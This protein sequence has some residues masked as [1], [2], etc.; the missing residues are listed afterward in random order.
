VPFD[1][2]CLASSIATLPSWLIHSLYS[3][4][5]D[6]CSDPR[7]IELTRDLVSFLNYSN[8]EHELNEAVRTVRMWNE[9]ARKTYSNFTNNANTAERS[10]STTLWD[11][12]REHSIQPKALVTFCYLLVASPATSQGLSL[13]AA[14]AYLSLLEYSFLTR[15]AS[16]TI[17]H[18]L[19]MRSCQTLLRAFARVEHG[20]IE[21]H[22][23]ARKAR[24]KKHGK[25]KAGE[26][27]FGDDMDETDASESL[28]PHTWM[29]SCSELCVAFAVDYL[30]Q[31]ERLYT[32]PSA[33]I[34]PLFALG[35]HPDLLA[36]LIETMLDLARIEV[37]FSPGARRTAE[38]VSRSHSTVAETA[39]AIVLSF[40]HPAHGGLSATLQLLLKSALSQV[41]FSAGLGHATSGAPV[42]PSVAGNT[43]GLKAIMER[44]SNFV[45]EIWNKAG[46]N[47]PHVPVSAAAVAGG[48]PAAPRCNPAIVL[49]SAGSFL[50]HVLLRSCVSS[51][52]SASSRSALSNLYSH[53]L[54]LFPSVRV[55]QAE[56]LSKMARNSRVNIR[57]FAVEIAEGVLTSGEWPWSCVTDAQ[58]GS[59]ARQLLVLILR[60][61][62][63]ASP[64]VR[65]KALGALTKVLEFSGAAGNEE[66]RI[67]LQRIM[68]SSLGT[69]APAGN[70]GGNLDFTAAAGLQRT[71][72]EGASPAGGPANNNNNT[73]GT[74]PAMSRSKSAFTHTPLSSLRMRGAAAGGSAAPD[75]NVSLTLD[76]SC[77]PSGGA[78][79]LHPLLAGVRDILTVLYRRSRDEKAVVRKAAI[80]ALEALLL[81]AAPA[82]NQ[83][84]EDEQD[85]EESNESRDRNLNSSTAAAAQS[86][87]AALTAADLQ[88]FY[89][90]CSDAN[91]SIRK[92]SILSLSSLLRRFVF[93]SSPTPSAPACEILSIARSN[94]QR[95][96]LG[97]VLP[98]VKDAEKSIEDAALQL[99]EEFLV[100]PLVQT[101]RN[102]QKENKKAIAAGKKA[103][104]KD[105]ESADPAHTQ[106]EEPVWS[107][108]SMLCADG[109]MSH[110]FQLAFSALLRADVQPSSGNTKR[111]DWTAAE[112]AKLVGKE[113]LEAMRP[114]ESNNT[115]SNESIEPTRPLENDAD[116]TND[117]LAF[118]PTAVASP[119]QSSIDPSR[120]RVLWTLMDSLCSACSSSP[121]CSS[122]LFSTVL[123]VW[124]AVTTPEDA[125][126][127]CVSEETLTRAIGCFV[128]LADASATGKSSAVKPEDAAQAAGYIVD[129]L[130]SCIA[131][132]GKNAVKVK[133]PEN[134]EKKDVTTSTLLSPQV[135]KKK[136]A[137][138][139]SLCA[140]LA[141]SAGNG[142]GMPPW[143]STLLAACEKA[144]A[145]FLKA[146]SQVALQA[147]PK[148]KKKDA[149]KNT[150]QQQQPK[151]KI[152]NESGL[153]STLFLTGEIL[154]QHVCFVAK[155]NSS[156]AATITPTMLRLLHTF[157]APVL[158]F[159]A[160]GEKNKSIATTTKGDVGKK[161]EPQEKNGAAMDTDQNDNN[162]SDQLNISAI[163]VSELDLTQTQSAS[164]DVSFEL[165]ASQTTTTA[166][167]P[168]GEPEVIPDASAPFGALVLSPAVRGHAFLA[169]GKACLRHEQLAKRSIQLFIQEL[170]RTS[171][172][173]SASASASASPLVQNNILLILMD[174]CR[175]YTS[176]VDPYLGTMSSLLSPLR[177]PPLL[178]KHAVMVLDLLVR[179]DYLKVKSNVHSE[180]G[181]GAASGAASSASGS[182]SLF[183]RFLRG[184]VDSDPATRSL[185]E[186][187]VR[188]MLVSSPVSGGT[189]GKIGA[190]SSGAGAGVNSGSTRIHMHFIELIFFLNNCTAHP[191]YN[192]FNA[193]SSSKTATSSSKS[194]SRD[195]EFALPGPIGSEEAARRF[196]IYKFCLSPEFLSDEQKFFLMDRLVAD[197]LNRVVE[198][199]FSVKRA[200]W[201]D[202]LSPERIRDVVQDT[203]L[204]LASEQMQL[205][206]AAAAGSGAKKD[207][208]AV[209]ALELQAELAE[210]ALAG[211]GGDSALGLPTGGSSRA[212]AAALATA[213]AQSIAKRK[214]LLKLL[215]KNTMETIWPVLFELKQI[216]YKASSLSSSSSTQELAPKNL[217]GP[218]VS[219]LSNYLLHYFSAL[220]SQ[221]RIENEEY[222]FSSNRLWEKEIKFDLRRWKQGL[223]AGHNGLQSADDSEATEE[224][225]QTQ[226][227]WSTLH[228]TPPK[229]KATTRFFSSSSGNALGFTPLLPSSA[230]NTSSPMAIRR[231]RSQPVPVSSPVE[232]VLRPEINLRNVAQFSPVPKLPQF[233]SPAVPQR[234]GSNVA[235]EG[236][237][238]L[239]FS[240]LS[241]LRVAT[242]LMTATTSTPAPARSLSAVALGTPLASSLTPAPLRTV[243]L[244]TPSSS[245]P[246]AAARSLSSAA[247]AVLG[248]PMFVSPTLRRTASMGN[249]AMK[250]PSFTPR[251]ARITNA[252]PK[253]ANR[254]QQGTK[255][256][257]THHVEE[258]EEE[259]DDDQD[260]SAQHTSA[261][262]AEVLSD[263][264]TDSGGDDG[265]DAAGATS[266]NQ[267]ANIVV[268]PNL[269][270][271]KSKAAKDKVW[272]V[273]LGT[274][275]E[276]EEEKQHG[277]EA[278]ASKKRR[279]NER[280]EPEQEAEQPAPQK[281][282]TNKPRKAAGLR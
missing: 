261:A 94:L 80:Q 11:V 137:L 196:R 184:L 116:M 243:S 262:V 23:T 91:L 250:P 187:S 198:D 183:Y 206:S 223:G 181:G 81:G 92:Q 207:G 231:T 61:C 62:S 72:S 8:G 101:M 170:E 43:N 270:A 52:S 195:G 247:A 78:A 211:S 5:L 201:M 58:E 88:I 253:S 42:A 121:V 174:L 90:G 155:S 273:R 258:G 267:E 35:R 248:T 114:P 85:K 191:L 27:P 244:G 203:L 157:I 68:R 279:K 47:A 108:L 37:L 21:N 197:V 160:Q 177:S 1:T 135:L 18:E 95:I 200:E 159:A 229:P 12:L 96:W 165:E 149:Q 162:A 118:P 102:K 144:L 84:Q 32:A 274:T 188:N 186:A 239:K 236:N 238:P 24:E 264:D 128:A 74:T 235:Q 180:A 226:S 153:C 232:R 82:E 124:N 98:M 7:C 164:N 59:F 14:A 152:L 64:S 269:D 104:K 221:Y 154:L 70:E 140:L 208:D 106:Q 218:S 185:V 281:Q 87:L 109:E 56:F 33:Q 282:V 28:N 249:S 77:F 167:E 29:E 127:I 242:P 255:R 268:V 277:E 259:V 2:T 143:E 212:N 190:T 209:D 131:E 36:H 199:S 39:Y 217:S 224:W 69:D 204:I 100:E 129:A 113:V 123:A 176:I 31:C 103:V 233:A 280:A 245:T 79:G 145:K 175:V 134:N 252:I 38:V 156:E 257:R 49:S 225:K 9:Q 117:E 41:L 112:L 51:S 246:A 139:N 71:L 260:G 275:E 34:Q 228:F 219:D 97:S 53:W 99:V 168:A 6:P 150:K 40:L 89:D 272:N 138:L 230:D 278:A 105:L 178:R 241:S 171:G 147:P 19:T 220:L 63:D 122:A 166:V 75:A 266:E 173:S 227:K 132:A 169:L 215:R 4:E 73:T 17:L 54:S 234:Q 125:Q 57:H 202:N 115:K 194:V 22:A 3:I 26:N 83:Q 111:G 265:E 55:S 60:R 213:H 276:R 205:S 263:A 193:S 141:R 214:L 210:M 146:A 161:E 130:G 254:P 93:V 126:R 86:M 110:Y 136:L 15:S 65:S 13:L 48:A 133:Q 179:E 45:T 25:K 189:A 216:F 148:S 66:V 120:V 67:Q 76:S 172:S 151:Q 50:Q 192:Q 222:V 107:M 30:G 142:A 271:E 16:G 163:S 119:V 10:N 182:C 46:L 251:L 256:T 158:N 240:S 44:V 20:R 237:T